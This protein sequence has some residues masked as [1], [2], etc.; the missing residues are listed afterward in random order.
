MSDA[1]I[2]L[3]I[4]ASRVVLTP[5]RSA[6]IRLELIVALPESKSVGLRLAAA[7]IGLCWPAG[8]DRPKGAYD[9]D[10]STYGLR[11]ADDL[12]GRGALVSDI[13]ATGAALIEAIATAGLPGLAEAKEAARPTEAPEGAA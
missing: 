5:P 9:G 8:P 4:G 13:V 7:T 6:T 1:P 2:S 12:I 10:V 11:V 3:Q